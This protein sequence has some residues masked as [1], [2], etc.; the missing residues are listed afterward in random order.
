MYY[1]FKF[2]VTSNSE[3]QSLPGEVA[4]LVIS[5]LCWFCKSSMGKLSFDRVGNDSIGFMLTESPSCP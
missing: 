3:W 2:E 4:T 1:L 5:N